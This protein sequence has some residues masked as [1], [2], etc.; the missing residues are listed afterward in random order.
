MCPGLLLT[1]ML[2]RCFIGTG[3]GVEALPL[4][5]STGN[6]QEF[7]SSDYLSI[8]SSLHLIFVVFALFNSLLR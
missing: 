1:R 3:V 6:F 2:F 4:R 5:R 8:Q 7:D